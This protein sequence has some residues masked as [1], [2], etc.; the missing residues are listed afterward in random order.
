MADQRPRRRHV[1]ARL[2]I[3]GWM[4]ALTALA[5]VGSLL[6]SQRLLLRQLDREINGELEQEMDEVGRLAGGRDPETGEPFGQDVAAIFQTFLRRNVPIEGE[7]F[8]TFVDGRPYRGTEAPVSLWEEPGAGGRWATLTAPG[9]GDL[10][11]DA[12]PVRWLA[13]PIH[14]PDGETLGV[15]VVTSF[16][17]QRRGDV[18]DAIATGLAVAGFM[19]AI[20]VLVGWVVAGRLLRPVRDVTDA[21]R[22]ITETDLARRIDAAGDDEI[23]ELAH[24]FNAMLDRLEAAFATQQ[25]FVDDAGHELRTPITIV[26]GHLELLGDDPDERREITALVTDELDRMSRIVDDLLLLA[27]RQHPDFVRLDPVEVEPLTAELYAKARA[28][29]PSRTWRMTE[30]ADATIAADAQRLT[31]AVMNLARNAVEHTGPDAQVS[32]GSAVAGDEVRI[33]VADTGPGVAPE[34][35]EAIF[36]R[37]A[38]GGDRRRRTDGAGLGLAIVRAVIE[39]H[40]GRVVV[41]SP[42]GGGARFTVVLPAAVP[43]GDTLVMT[44]TPPTTPTPRTGP[45]PSTTPSR[46]TDPTSP[47]SPQEAT[48]P[49]S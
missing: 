9:T 45:S 12:G 30:A 41:D 22:A 43:T 5:V 13:L 31:Q 29:D 38:R 24:T 46:A 15:F 32:L 14:D 3:L 48:W 40:G 20:A 27:K 4:L 16:L 34:D 36:E 2:R 26:R 42:P 11:T 18:T 49:A 1:S 6:L 47:M 33:W 23:A 28:L 19:L 37:F 25:A 7:A 10:S 44:P 8:Y 17:E 21:A 39:A 35:R